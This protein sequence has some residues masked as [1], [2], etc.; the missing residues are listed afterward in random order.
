MALG[1]AEGFSQWR[2][3]NGV[4]DQLIGGADTVLKLSQAR[5]VFF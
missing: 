2:G 5:L 1:I 4:E 3:Y